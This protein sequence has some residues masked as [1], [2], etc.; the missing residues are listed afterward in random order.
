MTAP[1]KCFAGCR[2]LFLL[3]WAISDQVKLFRKLVDSWSY[4]AEALVR[5]ERTVLTSLEEV[6]NALVACGKEQA[7]YE[8]LRQ[9]ETANLRAVELANERYRSG[10]VDFLNVLETQRSLLAVQEEL[11]RSERTMDQNLVHL[12][13]ALGGGWDA[14]H[15]LA[16]AATTTR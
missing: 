4:L 6:E 15:Q 1:E 5:Y 11:A 2:L 7:H 12:Y 9:S 16:D 8:A 10:L 3:C 14:E 13:R